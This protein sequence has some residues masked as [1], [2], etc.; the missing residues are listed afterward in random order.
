MHHMSVYAIYIESRHENELNHL[1]STIFSNNC[2]TEQRISA[3]NVLNILTVVYSLAVCP[4]FSLCI[5]SRRLTEFLATIK[6]NSR[7]IMKNNIIPKEMSS[8]LQ[9]HN[10]IQ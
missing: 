4:F 2:K 5:G 8:S 6:R 10:F 9:I 3:T 7:Q 1:A